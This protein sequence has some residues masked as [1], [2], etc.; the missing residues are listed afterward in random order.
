TAGAAKK[1]IKD[2]PQLSSSQVSF[3]VMYFPQNTATSSNFDRANMLCLVNKM[4]REKNLYP[5]VY[6]DSLIKL[7]QAHARFQANY[8]VVTHADDGGEMGDRLSALGFDWGMI[9][10]NVGAGVNGEAEIVD[11]WSKSAGHLAN[12]L[13]PDIR[14][15]GAGVSNGFW[16]QDFAAPIDKSSVVPIEQ[17]ET[18]PSTKNLLIY[19]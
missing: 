7:A 3:D 9:A 17:I 10:E 18:C 14:Y 19:S 2:W 13:H 15:M 1:Y 11:A 4:R 8:R 6:H 16:V 12:I 5:L